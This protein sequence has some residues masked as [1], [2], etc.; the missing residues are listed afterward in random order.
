MATATVWALVL[1]MNTG[2]RLETGSTYVDL[3]D[4]RRAAAAQSQN[5][6]RTRGTCEQR[7]SLVLETTT[8]HRIE[9]REPFFNAERC[10]REA[11]DVARGVGTLS[12]SC[13]PR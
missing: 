12:E 2:H 8:G 10:R 5:D 1:I 11:E 7:G 6:P 9:S 4:C 13:T 3:A